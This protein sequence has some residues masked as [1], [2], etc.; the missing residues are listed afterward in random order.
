MKSLGYLLIA[1][2]LIMWT[3]QIRS[4]ILSRYTYE[5]QFSNLWELADK[6]STIPAKQQYI[7]QFLYAL[8]AGE[9][10]GVFADYNATWLKTPNNSFAANV[11]AIQTLSDRLT[12]IQ[13]MDPASFQYN[14]AIQQ[15]TA[16]EQGEANRML[17]VFEGCYDRE[18]Y[19]IIWGWISVTLILFS[20]VALF[21]GL[22]FLGV[23]YRWSDYI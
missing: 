10:N 19:P 8:K 15:I 6:S 9:T 18:N 13:D 7:T 1:G 3:L 14:T 4:A 16:Q 2:A 5:K 20:T 12:Q 23:A 11:K 22:T 21:T 17:T